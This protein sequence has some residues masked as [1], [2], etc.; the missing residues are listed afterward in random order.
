MQ[1]IIIKYKISNQISNS[2]S[3]TRVFNVP[4]LSRIAECEISFPGSVRAI[5]RLYKQSY[6]NE[7][8]EP[9]P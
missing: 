6:I 5:Y 2:N 9:I 4:A 8:Q 1:T 7:I 3:V